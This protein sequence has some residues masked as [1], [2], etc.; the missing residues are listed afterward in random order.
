MKNEKGFSLIELVIFIVVTSILVSAILLAFVS[1]LTNTPTLIQN[2]KAILTAKQC[3]E[4]FLG[5]RR[6][7]GLN[8]IDNTCTDPLTIPS[9]C[10]VPN[11]Y[12]LTGSCRQ[13]T[14]RSDSNY[15]L[16]TLTVGGAGSAVLNVLI[17]QY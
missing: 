3:A 10:T 7:N 2:T 1:A 4:W 11:G 17:G 12:T 6:L 5:Q 14:V 15:R 16:I 9:Q 13:T 8:A